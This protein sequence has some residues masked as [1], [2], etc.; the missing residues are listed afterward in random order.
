M[1][2][3]IVNRFMG[4]YGGAETVIKEFASCLNERGIRNLVVALNISGEVKRLC[5]GID[6]IVPERQF[7]YAYR[8]T[9]L[10]SSLGI[11]REIATLRALVKKYYADFDVI[12]VHNFPAD[13]VAG[14]LRK[15]VVWMCNEV[16]DLYNNPNPSMALRIVRRC[17]ITLD[18]SL[19][20]GSI[21]TICVA[22]ELNASRVRAR[23]KRRSEIVPYGIDHIRF[24][25]TPQEKL[26]TRARYNIGDTAIILLQVG[27]ISPQ[28]NQL[29]SVRALKALTDK[30]IEATLILIGNADSP[31]GGIVKKFITA[32]NLAEKVVFTGHIKRESVMQF[33]EIADVC[34]F[35]VK[36]QGGWLAPFEALTRHKP[37]IV[38]DTMG[39]ACLIKKHGMGIVSADFTQAVLEF[40]HDQSKWRHAAA[41]A[42]SWI[43][44][45]LTWQKYTDSMIRVF[46][47][48]VWGFTNRRA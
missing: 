30:G 5:A 11:I 34:L 29:E 23:Y 28:K 39:A 43:R 47:D 41:E 14:G 1:K 4:I 18:K 12:N 9:G 48:A 20:N 26:Q 38:S 10:M 8:S 21:Q 16:P 44:D 36:D 45:N 7:P 27:V 25:G 42:S 40:V 19:V 13:W 17:G 31:Y 3:L 6:I 33:Y 32:S 46:E 35:P 37:V 24:L 15:P 22:D 2:V